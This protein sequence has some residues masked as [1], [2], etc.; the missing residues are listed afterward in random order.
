MK[1]KLMHIKLLLT[2]H[3]EVKKY[4]CFGCKGTTSLASWL[5]KEMVEKKREGVWAEG[6]VN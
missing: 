6:I 1:T 4:H 5:G 3:K 2:I